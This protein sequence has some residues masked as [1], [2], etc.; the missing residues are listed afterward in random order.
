LPHTWLWHLLPLWQL[1]L[2]DLLNELGCEVC[3]A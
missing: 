1:V 2:H 3:H